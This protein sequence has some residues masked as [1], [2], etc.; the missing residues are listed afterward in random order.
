[1]PGRDFYASGAIILACLA[2]SSRVNNDDVAVLVMCL[3]LVGHIKYCNISKSECCAPPYIPNYLVLYLSKR[4]KYCVIL[5]R[6]LSNG[7]CLL[8]ILQSQ[9]NLF[10]IS[11]LWFVFVV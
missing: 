10:I 3:P 4:Q 5:H 6:L 9:R 7:R 2:S 8:V 1:M 11:T